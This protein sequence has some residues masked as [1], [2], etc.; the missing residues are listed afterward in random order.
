MFIDAGAAVVDIVR[1]IGLVIAEAREFRK[2]LEK[3]RM[4]TRAPMSA[5]NVFVVKNEVVIAVI[6]SL[7][8]VFF[9]Q[10]G[11]LVPSKPRGLFIL[12]S[13]I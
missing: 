11:K 4:M 5:E 6:C 3:A 12:V 7:A 10:E 13:S 8:D 1:E 2:V 9:I